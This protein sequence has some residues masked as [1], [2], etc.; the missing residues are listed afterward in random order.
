M[1]C[2]TSVAGTALPLASRNSIAPA[3]I[4]TL[5]GSSGSENT[6]RIVVVSSIGRNDAGA[7]G[8]PPLT[9]SSAGAA[10]R[11]RV[12][13]VVNENNGPLGMF[14]ASGARLALTITSYFVPAASGGVI[15]T[16]RPSL[17]TSTAA[18]TGPAGPT[19]VSPLAAALS[20]TGSENVTTMRE[21]SGTSSWPSI[22]Y[23][24]TT[25]G[26]AVSS[27]FV[28]SAHAATARQIHKAARPRT[29]PIYQARA[30]Y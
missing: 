29:H 28:P 27:G 24:N 11:G 4:R 6:K 25:P 10:A 22:G 26:A 2:E 19:T 18:L 7:I 30:R 16:L 15:E 9:A 12:L 13:R 8:L 23:V 14:A 1:P 3:P 20:T 21:P 17:D 5:R